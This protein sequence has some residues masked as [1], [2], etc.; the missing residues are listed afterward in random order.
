MGWD[1]RPAPT[2]S[3]PAC[4]RELLM[5]SENV[6]PLDAL[7]TEAIVAGKNLRRAIKTLAAH[8]ENRRLEMAHQTLIVEETAFSMRS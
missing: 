7:L 5:N 8:L 3:R 2:R 1:S 6:D 4:L